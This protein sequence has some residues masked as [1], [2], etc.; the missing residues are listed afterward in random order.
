[1]HNMGKG[2]KYLSK[3]EIS[4]SGNS[5]PA[6][7]RSFKKMFSDMAKDNQ[8]R[9]EVEKRYKKPTP[10]QAQAFSAIEDG[11]D[12]IGCSPTGTGKTLAFLIPIFR[13]L[14][15]SKK[16]E[17]VQKARCRCLVITPT[18]ELAVQISRVAREFGTGLKVILLMAKKGREE[19]N[20][21]ILISSPRC[22]LTHEKRYDLSGLSFLVVDEIDRLFDCSGLLEHLDLVFSK[23]PASAQKLFFS[24]TITK[25]AEE[26]S[27]TVMADPLVIFV[28]KKNVPCQNV[29]QRLVFTDGED[30]KIQ[31]INQILREGLQ[32]PVLVFVDSANRA[33]KVHEL[34][35]KQ[36]L[37]SG[38]I[39]RSLSKEQKSKTMARFRNGEIFFLVTTDLLS[40]G[41]DFVDVGTVLSFDIPDNLEAYIHRVGRTGRGKNTGN[42]IVFFSKRDKKKLAVVAK[43]ISESGQDVPEWMLE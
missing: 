30:G 21:D 18:Q 35:S 28:G 29:R 13:S 16:M 42:S 40:R 17:L 22:F 19:K 32:P 34:L 27:K 37:R 4:V 38:F 5:I 15:N 43:A 33:E 14:I 41:I 6:P 12:V 23:V 10:I 11:R 20:V 9:M 36:D 24:A 31:A 39:H 2:E 26:L 3:K 7:V 25:N 1:M 8:L